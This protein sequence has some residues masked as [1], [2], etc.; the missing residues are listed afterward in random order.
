MQKE[1]KNHLFELQDK[2]YKEFHSSLCPN[3]DN[4]I[5]VRIPELRKLAKQ[6]AKENPKE[7]IENP[8]KKQ[9]YEEIMLE[10]FV[11]GYMKAT[12]EEK[13][14]YLDNFIPE[15]DNWAVC[16]CTA[17][18]LKFIDKYKKEVWE[19]LQKYI[20]SKKEFEKRFAIIILMDYYLTDE[21]IDKVLEIYNKIDSDQYY[22][23]MGIAWAISVCFVKYR[24]KTRKILDNN[25]LS[26]FT[27]NKS[28]QKIIESTRVDKETKEELKKL[29]K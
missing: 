7:F 9:Y 12:L 15:I 14:H 2:K 29:K 20:N 6:I 23:Q 18:T 13:L 10:G 5:G 28:I 19:Y 25:N 4:I 1:I 26:T 3:V 16:D 11:I 22:V 17:S 8:V 24:E 21:Y 27:H